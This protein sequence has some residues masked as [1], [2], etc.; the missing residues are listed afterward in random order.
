MPGCSKASRGLFVPPRVARIFT[1]PAVS[2]SPPL[3]QSSGGSA[4][5]AGRNLPDKGLRYLRTVRVT[6]AVHRGFSSG[7]APLPLTF[8]HWAGVARYTSGFPLAASCVFVKQSPEVLRC[9]PPGLRGRAPSPQGAPL[10][11]KLRGP[12]AEFLSG[13]SL[14]RLGA[15][16]PAHLWRFA[17]RAP[18]PL[19]GGLFSE[20]WA[21][22]G[23]P[24]CPGLLSPLT[25]TGYRGERP[26]ST[27]GALTTLPRPPPLRRGVGGAGIL[28]G[29][30]SPTPCGLGLGPD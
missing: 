1:G 30:P 21:H 2:P 19:R 24:G 29:S 26:M 28:T 16:T 22:Q 7:L 17:V 20:A 15:L 27:G 4:F 6:A 12:F 8:R 5:H 18:T 13:G 23:R 11:P 10:L 25:P 9:G 3:R 14:V